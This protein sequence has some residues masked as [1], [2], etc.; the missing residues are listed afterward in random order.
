M[1]AF[2]FGPLNAAVAV[3]SA[4]RDNEAS[5]GVS[6]SLGYQPNGEL[7]HRRGD[8]ADVMVHMRLRREDWLARDL[9]EDVSIDGFDACR[10][11]FGL[12]GS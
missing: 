7:R 10:H 6:R 8:G 5:L 11:L 2:A 1:L 12:G 9:G 3:T 4:W